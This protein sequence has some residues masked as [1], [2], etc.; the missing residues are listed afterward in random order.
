MYS[1]IQ[2]CKS[3]G[4]DVKMVD[5]APYSSGSIDFDGPTAKAVL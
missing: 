3:E 4:L 5:E 1:D 2:I